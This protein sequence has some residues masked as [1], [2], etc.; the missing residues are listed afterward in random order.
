MRLHITLSL[1]RPTT[2]PIDHLHELQALIYRFLDRSSPEFA[3]FL[4]ERGYASSLSTDNR[5]FK[6][7][8]FCGLRVEKSRRRLQNSELTILPG[9]V[10]WFLSSPNEEFLRHLV[11][12]L[13]CRGETVR[14]AGATFEIVAA[15][16]LPFPEFREREEYVCL[17]PIV[18]AVPLL[19]GGTRYLLPSD[20]AAFSEA[21]RANLLQKY[22]VLRGEPPTETEFRLEF[23]PKFMDDP[24]RQTTKLTDFKGT[25]IKGAF[26]PFALTTSPELHRFAHDTG[27]GEKNSCGFGMIEVR[28]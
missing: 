8:V 12:G 7:F 15:T 3:R 13:L 18:A 22:A 23:L 9:T 28:P 14:V 27:L 19:E 2:I 1:D 5:R 26:A 10:D 21:V 25:K 20:G 6:S 24:S 16:T 17:S 4:H 11:T